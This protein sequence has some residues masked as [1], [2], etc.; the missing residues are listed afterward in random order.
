M[1]SDETAYLPGRYQGCVG[2]VHVL[3]NVRPVTRPRR[4]FILSQ[5]VLWRY[6]SPTTP[7]H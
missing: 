7:T 1:I 6:V 3:N 4:R 5:Q 2:L